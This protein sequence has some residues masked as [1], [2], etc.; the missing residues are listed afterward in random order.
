MTVIYLIRHAEAEGNMYRVFQG[1]KDV[2]LTERGELQAKALAERFRDIPIDAVYSSDLYRASAT[3]AGICR[4]HALPLHR[5]AALR[6]QFVGPWEGHPLGEVARTDPEQMENFRKNLAAWYLPGA[7][8][9][10]QVRERVMNTLKDIAARH[11][12][13]TVAVVSHGAAIRYVLGA[14]R[15]DDLDAISRTRTGENTGVTV[16]GAENGVFRITA[17][18]DISHLE[19]WMEKLQGRPYRRL[20]SGLQ[21]G[22]WYRDPTAE[23]REQWLSAAGEDP[24]AYGEADVRLAMRQDKAVGVLAMRPERGAEQARGWIDVLW[25]SP[26]ERGNS[27]GTQLL[28][29]AVYAFREK[30]RDLLLA[31]TAAEEDSGRAF[32]EKRGFRPSGVGADGDVVMEKSIALR[33]LELPA[34]SDG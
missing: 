14:I 11:D 27:Y 7:E 16:L 17:P 32:L 22:L 28:G 6:E 33:P 1:H 9:V 8:T 3:A 26:E 4:I 13:Q 30:G 12:G 18:E 25:I 21:V 23:E 20:R 24:A 5:T 31:E 29:Q 2:M 10:E 34:G 15:G 19:Q